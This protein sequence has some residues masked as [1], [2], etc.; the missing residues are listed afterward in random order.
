MLAALFAP[1]LATTVLLRGT[2]GVVGAS[3][4]RSAYEVLFAPLEPHNRRAAKPL[5]DVGFD[6]MGMLLG[7]GMVATVVAA[8]GAL[9]RTVLL[10][11]VAALAL[12]RVLLSPRLQ[13]DTGAR[14]PTVCAEASW[15]CRT[16]AC[17]I[18]ARW[19]RSR[20]PRAEL[21]R[22]VLLEAD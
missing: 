6:S 22:P 21:N 17:W 5:L 9:A 19:A 13:A 7:S 2:D 16:P 18:V 4:H 3:L 8:T 10:A 1:P 12:V 11:L 20:R 15:R 14:S